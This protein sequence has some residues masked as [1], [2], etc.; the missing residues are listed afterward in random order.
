MKIVGGCTVTLDFELQII[1]LPTVISI[2]GQKVAN[3]FSFGQACRFR[4]LCKL[5]WDL[6]ER[7]AS[8]V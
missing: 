1:H 8:W 3:Q 4:I 6:S 7:F 2:V 5:Y